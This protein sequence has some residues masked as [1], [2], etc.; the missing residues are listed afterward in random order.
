MVFEHLRRSLRDAMSRVSSPADARAA[1]ALMREAVIEA[2]AGVSALRTDR[3]ATR[4]QLMLERAELATV[5]R[6]GRLAADIGDTET[7]EIAARFERRH[8]ERITVLERKL[9]AQEAELALADREA[10]E[11]AAQLKATADGVASPAESTASM[12][13]ERASGDAGSELRR[14]TDRLA[15][16]AQAERQLAELKKRMRK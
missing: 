6:R 9:A 8:V 14:A 11:M 3:D 12:D 1:L 4:Q 15:H 2:R 13:S 7:V 16:E 5:Q 10:E